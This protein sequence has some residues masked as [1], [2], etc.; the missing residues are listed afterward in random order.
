MVIMTVMAQVVERCAVTDYKKKARVQQ[1][2]RRDITMPVAE[3]RVLCLSILFYIM[4]FDVNVSFDA[5]RGDDN[6]ALPATSCRPI[7]NLRSFFPITQPYFFAHFS[8]DLGL[9]IIAC[10]S[11]LKKRP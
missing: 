1:W 6:S 2:K 3:V 4:L 7:S 9:F 10:V 8:N 5:L 11:S